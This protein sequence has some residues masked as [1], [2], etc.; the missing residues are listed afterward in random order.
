MAYKVVVLPEPVGPV[1][2]IIPLGF[3]IS[4]LKV[5]ARAFLKPSDSTL[6]K[7]LGSRILITIDS[8]NSAGSEEVLISIVFSSKAIEKRPS[9][10]RS[11]IFNLSLDKSFIREV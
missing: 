7:L 3:L 8:P 5:S 9:W 11:L 2:I 10:G 1:T 4:L 6:I